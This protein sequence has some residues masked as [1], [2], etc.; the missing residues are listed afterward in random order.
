MAN[1]HAIMYYDFNQTGLTV[2]IL[3]MEVNPLHGGPMSGNIVRL[4]PEVVHEY[5]TSHRKQNH[6]NPT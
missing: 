2:H 1:T 4:V 5:P 6:P 3:I